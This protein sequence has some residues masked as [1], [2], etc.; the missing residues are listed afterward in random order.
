MNKEKMDCIDCGTEYCPCKLAESGECILCSQLQ[1]KCFCDCLNWKGVCIYQELYNNGN[2]AKEGRKTYNCQVVNSINLEKNLT[3]IKFKAPHKLVLDLVKPGSFVFIR[4]DENYFFDIPISI[5]D[6]DIDTNILTIVIEV[7]GIKTK[8]IEN[9]QKGDEIVIRGP[10]WNGVFG[11]DNINAQKGNNVLVLAKGIGAA[12]MMPVIRK[13]KNNFNEIDVFIDSSPFTIDFSKELLESYNLTSKKTNLLNKGKL[14]EEGKFI[15]L[16]SI[17][18][19]NIKLIHL[20]GADILT[21]S[22]IEYLEE[23]N[24][25]NI[26]LSC[27]NNFKMCCGEGVCGACTTRFS[28]HR[29][30]RFCKMQSD[31]RRIFEGRRYI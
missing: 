16:N 28:G 27:C 3:M 9:I 31:P 5:M 15:V 18:D 26:L 20:A 6:A 14:S 29:V 13:F 22:I 24:E 1:G 17:K 4:T 30:K 21:Y 7:R 23:I 25:N 8:R 11:I 12:P 19:K 2:K 10:Y